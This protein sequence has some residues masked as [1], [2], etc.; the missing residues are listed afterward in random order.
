MD[1]FHQNNFFLISKL[2][3]A[4]KYSNYRLLSFAIYNH[5]ELFYIKLLLMG[6]FDK[7]FGK[8]DDKKK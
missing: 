5:F 1:V 8:K 6:F 2:I 7:L 4:T 3:M